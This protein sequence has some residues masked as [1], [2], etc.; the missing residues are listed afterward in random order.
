M[1]KRRIVRAK[2][3]IRAVPT[4]LPPQR[5][6]RDRTRTREAASVATIAPSSS[7]A[8]PYLV[9]LL[10]VAL[11]L[12]ALVAAAALAPVRAL[13]QPLSDRL[14]GRREVLISALAALAVGIAAGL[15][16]VALS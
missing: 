7:G 4:K 5:P 9:L 11:A 13:P 3:H 6:P 1:A 15:V 16:V 12:L 2:R 14:D 8:P 10:G